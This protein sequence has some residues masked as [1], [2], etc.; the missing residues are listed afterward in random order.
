MQQGLPTTDRGKLS[1]WDLAGGGA[2]AQVRDHERQSP[3][4]ETGDVLGWAPQMQT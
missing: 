2:D 4:R 3:S 1:V